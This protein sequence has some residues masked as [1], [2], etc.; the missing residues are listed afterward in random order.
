M[1]FS[2]STRDSRSMKNGLQEASLWA[3][4]R[5]E[6]W[7]RVGVV[8]MGEVDGV[9]ELGKQTQQDWVTDRMWTE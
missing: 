2:I 9:Q 7:A 5:W 6:T 1:R 8:V 3:G 4:E